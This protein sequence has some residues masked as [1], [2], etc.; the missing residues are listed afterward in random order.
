MRDVQVFISNGYDTN[1]YRDT[2]REVL[3]SLKE[4]LQYKMEYDVTLSNWDYRRAPPAVV[5]AGSLCDS[6]FEDRRP[7]PCADRNI[8]SA[9]SRNH[10]R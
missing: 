3:D 10:L 7:V 2:A 9:L 1:R 4:L 6:K 8:S 5:P